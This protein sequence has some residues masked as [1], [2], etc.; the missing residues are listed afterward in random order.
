MSSF[1]K[2]QP[3]QPVAGLAE[4]LW[5]YQKRLGFIVH[6]VRA[7]HDRPP[8]AV[9]VLDVGCG[10]GAQLAIPLATLGFDVTGVD[11]HEGSITTARAFGSAGNFVH[12][13]V[14][15]LPP[16]K[17][18]VVIV[19]EVLEHLD[20]PESLLAE[21]LPY[22]RDDG[23]LFITVPN[24]YGEFEID[25]RLY[26]ALR[27]DILFDGLYRGLRLLLRR[28]SRPD[29]AGSQDESDHVQRFTLGRLRRMFSE[30]RLEL[31]AER[32]TSVASGPLVAHTLARI[33]GFIEL[34]TRLADNLPMWASSAWM[35]VL[36]R[37][38]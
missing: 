12:G 38:Q 15:E 3:R 16:R 13:Q 19:C 28:Q 2:A 20:H 7:W 1:M 34:N 9:S 23:L 18:D 11:T 36:R 8:S 31:C 10:T 5:G 33:P 27:L 29:V 14:S 24:G 26:R 22:L 6:G 30:H 35:F 17:Y 4:N 21:T 37:R 32:A 25:R